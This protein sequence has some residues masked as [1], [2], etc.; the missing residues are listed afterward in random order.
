MNYLNIVLFILN[1]PINALSYLFCI[2][3]QTSIPAAI[4]SS[5]LINIALTIPSS[6][7]YYRIFLISPIPSFFLKQNYRLT[8]LEQFNFFQKKKNKKTQKS[9]TVF[10][11]LKKIKH[12]LILKNVNPTLK[13]QTILDHREQLE[14]IF[15]HEIAS[16]RLYDRA[17]LLFFSKKTYLEFQFGKLPDAF[18][19]ED[20][21]NQD[22]FEITF[23]INAINEQRNWDLTSKSTGL[24]LG[25]MG[26]G[27]SVLINSIV[28]QLLFKHFKVKIVLATGKDP[29]EDFPSLVNHPSVTLLCHQIQDDYKRLISEI[30]HLLNEDKPRMS[31]LFKQNKIKKWFELPVPELKL[32]IIDEAFT[33]SSNGAWKKD[34]KLF[35]D[36]ISLGRNY[37]HYAIVGTQGQRAEEF[38]NIGIDPD[39]FL[40]KIGSKVSTPQLSQTLYNDQEIGTDDSL[41]K[42]KMVYT[43]GRKAEIIRAIYSDHITSF[44]NSFKTEI[45]DPETSPSLHNTSDKQLIKN[46]PETEPK[47]ECYSETSVIQSETPTI[48]EIAKKSPKGASPLARFKKK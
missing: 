13:K 33:I 22:Q 9:N 3:T 26:S 29:S 45:T 5:L 4:S 24:I 32:I 16:V 6:Y 41:T 27:K 19:F 14:R 11:T 23:G 47:N 42:G 31:A 46:E 18:K 40:F 15:K 10:P 21:K 44:P 39:R 36:L 37:G 7:I 43:E 17:F 28:T 20:I 1:L 30:R 48:S 35:N 12:G 34:S 2:A 38:K 25:A 8:D